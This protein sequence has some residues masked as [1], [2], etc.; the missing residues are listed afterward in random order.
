MTAHASFAE[1]VRPL[2]A[3]G[4][5][6]F[7]CDADKRPLTRH[8]FKDASADPD[9][10]AAWDQMHPDALVGQPTGGGLI[11][12]DIDRKNGADGINTMKARGYGV[13]KTFVYRTRSG[14]VH[15]YFRLPDGLSARSS[16]G[17]LG[18]GLDIRA[19]GGYVIRHDLEGLP[20]ANEGVMAEAPQWLLDFATRTTPPAI[21]HIP[22][23]FANND[24][25]SAGLYPQVTPD[26]IAACLDALSPDC[27]RD[28]WIRVGMALH[29]EY[30][31]DDVGLDLWDAWSAR[32][33]HR[34][35]GADEV[36][37]QWASFKRDA[38]G[39]SIGTLIQMARD[40]GAVLPDT[41]PVAPTPTT[42]QLP[43]PDTPARFPV[44]AAG[45]FLARPPAEWHIKGLIPRAG[46]VVL[47][48]ES[49]AG[50]SFVA[51]DLAGAIVR[52]VNW[53]GM[54]TKPGRV[55]IV[56]AEGAGGFGGRV[57]A[58]E[59]HHDISFASLPLGIVDA[60]PN[61]MQPADV[62][63]LT[64][65]ITDS[66]GA[67]LI[68]L[69]TFAQMTPGANEN[70]GED[71]GKAL[72]HCKFLHQH[73]GATVM[74]VHHAGKDT[75]RGAR[76]WSGLKAAAD[77]E[78]E[79]SR[80]AGGRMLKVTKSKDGVDGLAYGFDLETLVV[81]TD[82]D[83]DQITSCVVK[84]AAVP[85][86][87][88]PPGKW[89]Q[90]AIDAMRTLIIDLGSKAAESTIIAEMLAHEGPP[91]EGRDRRREYA[92]NGLRN[93]CKDGRHGYTLEG[94]IVRSTEPLPVDAVSG[95]KRQPAQAP[96][97]AGRAGSP[98]REPATGTGADQSEVRIKTN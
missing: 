55:V 69:D 88:R 2:V 54:R 70:A 40:T 51:L 20:A 5:P 84:G 79:V 6:V 41:T 80:K 74:L 97:F 7:P 19:D 16:A 58:Y 18:P 45:E 12:L 38:G 17:Q 48:G 65:S 90:L 76:G 15:F 3:A 72:G 46:L 87:T 57:R 86:E 53:R 31:G 75:S 8:G 30:Q 61:L 36:A 24:D 1:R 68:I 22:S 29:S 92:S 23:G 37:K 10:I 28:T 93:V 47:Y 67:D 39:V 25:L 27:N 85:V 43:A 9:Q 66:G 50:K 77:A 89:E 21:V 83:G 60:A 52:G 71:M 98:Y 96:S 95:K 32:A 64:H 26:R 59:Q 56:A 33:I 91:A 73:T 4:I 78:L 81:G 62:A 44:L 11:V 42:P 34:Y 35:P 94:G 63:A 49:G 82:A 13:P 14:G